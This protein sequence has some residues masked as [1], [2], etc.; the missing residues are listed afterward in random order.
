MTWSS[1]AVVS[2]RNVCISVNRS[3]RH[4]NIKR[5]RNWYYEWTSKAYLFSN[6][7]ASIINELR[8]IKIFYGRPIIIYTLRLPIIFLGLYP[9]GNLN[10]H[11]LF[12]HEIKS[13]CSMSQ[14]L[15]YRA[16]TEHWHISQMLCHLM[17]GLGNDFF[18]YNG[19]M[20]I[21]LV[22]WDLIYFWFFCSIR[23]IHEEKITVLKN[24]SCFS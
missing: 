23:M 2:V 13:Q 3:V 7:V 1:L 22:C 5:W 10:I 20:D 8:N 17:N 12:I 15:T 6:Y 18:S 14:L 9:N 16:I 24:R 11:N 19:L 21:L 4:R